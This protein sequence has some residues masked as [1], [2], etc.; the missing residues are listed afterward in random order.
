MVVGIASVGCLGPVPGVVAII[1]GLVALSQIKKNPDHMGG[2]SFA[3]T[4][5]ITGGVTVLVY[6][7]IMIFYVIMIAIAVANH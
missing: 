1:L 6:G 5:V 2:E 3:W 4:G 7:I